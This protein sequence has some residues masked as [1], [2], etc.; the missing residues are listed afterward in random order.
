MR[1]T[2][3]FAQC[4]AQGLPDASFS[5]QLSGLMAGL[6]TPGTYLSASGPPGGVAWL[7]VLPAG[8]AALEP[9]LRARVGRLT[10]VRDAGP[11]FI[12]GA[13]R[14]AIVALGGEGHARALAFGALV[15]DATC[16]PD[17]LLLL[18]AWSAGANTQ[19]TLAAVLEV[20]ELRRVLSEFTLVA[21]EQVDVARP[22]TGLGPP[23]LVDVARPFTG[24]GT[25]SVDVARPFTGLGPLVDG[26]R[27]FAGPDAAVHTLTPAPSPDDLADAWLE[28]DG[29]GGR[30]RFPIVAAQ[31]VL[32]R[33]GDVRVEDPRVSRRH[34][35]VERRLDGFVLQVLSTAH[36]VEVAGALRAHG[37][38]PL[39]DGATFVMGDTHARFVVTPGRAPRAPFLQVEQLDA[40]F[41]GLGLPSPP[42]PAALAVVATADSVTAPAP[43]G[44]QLAI[45]WSP[46][47]FTYRWVS[48][49]WSLVLDRRAFGD[50][51]DARRVAD[52]FRA[53]GAVVADA[54]THE[55]TL[56]PPGH[57]HRME[58]DATSAAHARWRTPFGVEYL[59][60][61][62]QAALLEALTWR[63]TN[64]L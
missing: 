59:A 39:V 4:R 50:A 32:G 49:T 16:C 20:P 58:V 63:R 47:H 34:A 17:G 13:P 15:V 46:G 19:P 43:H 24:L 23:N 53:L 52:T 25:N 57:V 55:G 42:V 54:M 27:P 10:E 6:P 2:V 45:T 3:S 9:A 56:A 36:G 48:R 29:P 37:T 8:G 44:P 35:V 41:S 11:L 5:L 31:V 7:A 61:D 1:V 18:G 14:P 22:F 21:P 30:G 62:A 38:F 33:T 60:D 51:P 26:A 64:R 40:F 12:A 28:L